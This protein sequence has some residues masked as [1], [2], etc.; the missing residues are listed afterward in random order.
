MERIKKMKK[1]SVVLGLFCLMA[2]V[3]AGCVRFE[4]TFTVGLDNKVSVSVQQAYE[5]EKSEET[6]LKQ[7]MTSQEIAE[8][9][10]EF[11]VKT[12]EG[13]QYYVNEVDKDIAPE[14]LASSFPNYIFTKDKFYMYATA[15]EINGDAEV[16]D[17]DVSHIL[18]EL[19]EMG[20]DPKD[21][22]LIIK[23]KLPS[24]IVKTNG[25]LQEDK[26]VAVWK[27]RA[28]NADI[29]EIYAYTAGDAADMAADRKTVEKQLAG[30]MATDEPKQTSPAFDP[31]ASSAPSNSPAPGPEASNTPAFPKVK[32]TD[33]KAPVIKG[34][35]KNK[36]YKKKATVYVT[37]NK[38]LKKVTL[39][40]KKV[41]LKKVTK[42]KWKGYYKFVVKK[43]GKS[44]VIAYDASGNKRK[45]KFYV[46]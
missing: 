38:Q 45:I 34:V 14:D 1:I 29:E 11:E 28:E 30:V 9:M 40:G 25:S 3:L 37:D 10:K 23:V 12:I 41:S 18:D 17:E 4:E 5:K 13:K 46:K 43:K 7:G 27:L 19:V 31:I 39:N 32:K 16:S 21:M 22:E 44:T 24:E 33:K 42:G 26:Q 8:M 20:L 6:L 15:S 2:V 35:K 36:T